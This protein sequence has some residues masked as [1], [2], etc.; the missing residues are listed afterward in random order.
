MGP[1]RRGQ[2]WVGCRQRPLSA[3][4]EPGRKQVLSEVAETGVECEGV[5]SRPCLVGD[6]G[7]GICLRL[8]CRSTEFVPVLSP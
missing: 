2:W 1:V 3:V 8:S 7:R 6:G 5:R 4:G